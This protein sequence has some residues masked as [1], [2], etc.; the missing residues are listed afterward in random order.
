MVD[1]RFRLVF[2]VIAMTPHAA[3]EEWM[4]IHGASMELELIFV[5]AG[6]CGAPFLSCTAP[7]RKI[8]IIGSLYS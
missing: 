8:S 5:G 7:S 6:G 4:C 2:G 3:D 1:L